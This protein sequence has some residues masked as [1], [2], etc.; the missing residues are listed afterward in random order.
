MDPDSALLVENKA[1]FPVIEVVFAALAAL[2]LI[3]GFVIF[4][5]KYF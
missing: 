4:K 3:F 2:V 5:K 1:Q